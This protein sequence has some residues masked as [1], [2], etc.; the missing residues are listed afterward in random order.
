MYGRMAREVARGARRWGR[1]AIARDWGTW[2]VLWRV[3]AWLLRASR[4][5]GRQGQA[6][7][8]AVGWAQALSNVER[9]AAA[10]DMCMRVRAGTCS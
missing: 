1:A 3:C 7:L 8:L 9:T 4:R 2:L 6:S 5:N 10:A